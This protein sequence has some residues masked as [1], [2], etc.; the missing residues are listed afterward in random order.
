[1]KSTDHLTAMGDT[2]LVRNIIVM[3]PNDGYDLGLIAMD[4]AMKLFVG[5]TEQDF[6][7]GK[8]PHTT[9]SVRLKNDCA[10]STMR[11]NQKWWAEIGRP[12]RVR[13]AC[14]QNKILLQPGT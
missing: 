4:T 11:M 10:I 8:G 14:D 2:E 9:V 6:L 1:M 12:R 5:A 3:H 13:L 7:S